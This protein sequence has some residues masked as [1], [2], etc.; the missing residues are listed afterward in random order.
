MRDIYMNNELTA[1]TGHCNNSEN[2]IIQ[3]G[4]QI[5]SWGTFALT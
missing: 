1:E 3:D 2:M 5:Y 4:Y